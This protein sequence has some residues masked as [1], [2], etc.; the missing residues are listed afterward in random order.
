M[1]LHFLALIH[2]I[3]IDENIIN[4]FD[5]TNVLPRGNIKLDYDI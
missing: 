2:F 5:K 4:L 1:K 3:L